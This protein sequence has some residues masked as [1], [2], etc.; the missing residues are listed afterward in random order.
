MIMIDSN[1]K[2]G[3]TFLMSEFR[4]KIHSVNDGWSVSPGEAESPDPAASGLMMVYDEFSVR[5]IIQLAFKFQCKETLEMLQIICILLFF[6][7]HLWTNKLV[8]FTTDMSA[9]CV[10]LMSPSLVIPAKCVVRVLVE[11]VWC[12]SLWTMVCHIFVCL[13]DVAG[14]REV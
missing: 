4:S 1:N 12:A 8:F 7:A 2:A 9:G 10:Q 11:S 3:D 13:D 5:K 6:S 14:W